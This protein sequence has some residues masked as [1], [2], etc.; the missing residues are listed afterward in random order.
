[1]DLILNRLVVGDGGALGSLST[2]SGA[3]VACTLEHTY[4]VGSGWEPKV[5]T[6]LYICVR[7]THQLA[8]MAAPFET[9]EVVN[10]PGHTDILFHCGNTEADSS[11]CILLGDDVDDNDQMTILHSRDAFKRFMVL[12]KGVYTFRLT[13]K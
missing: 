9:F 8:G 1:M 11:G 4:L 2:P 7:S 12:Q 13:V 5:P 6:G 10:V 3:E